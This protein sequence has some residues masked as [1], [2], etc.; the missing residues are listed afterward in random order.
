MSAQEQRAIRSS[1]RR[2]LILFAPVVA[3][4]L[5][6]SA[7][8]VIGQRT[9][10]MRDLFQFHVPIKWSQAELMR[11]GELP[12]I[13]PQRAGGQ[14]LIGNL[15]G[16][17]LY[18]D[19]LLYLVAP[20]LWAVNA[21]F[22]LHLLLAP[23]SLY[24]L[25]RRCGL[26]RE[27][28]WA[29]GTCF[30]VSGFVLSQFNL[31]NM[32]AG[33]TWAPAFVGCCL[34]AVDRSARRWAPFGVAL[35]WALLLLGGEPVLAAQALLMAALALAAR[36]LLGTGSEADGSAISARATLPAAVGLAAGTLL[37]L[38]QLV[39]LVRILGN[40]YRGFWGFSAESSLLASMNPVLMVEGLVPFF[41]G[42]PDHSFWGV[43]LF[44]AE[45]GPLFWSLFPGALCVALMLSSVGARDWG[46]RWA[47]LLLG[48]GIFLA[49]GSHN[50]VVSALAE[51][52]GASILRYPVKFMLLAQVGA[53]LLAGFGLERARR[54][55]G[56]LAAWLVALSV[57]YGRRLGSADLDRRRQER[58]ASDR[59]DSRHRQAGFDRC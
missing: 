41:Y 29:A 36:R 4:L 45:G 2:R 44:G 16:V 39:E 28:A 46:W 33:V 42:R 30:A 38:P 21:H 55:T 37:A 3:A 1:W 9:L 47:V 24:F 5:L 6:A 23:F 54:R 22:W 18:P 15:N 48:L 26:G 19:N 43:S 12:F 35:T 40:S 11:Q 57:L 17:P 59:A 58:D 8:L 51:A 31:Y 56:L 53:S 34:A 27:A 20:P 52:P 10:F 25:A 13:D 32:I 50:P 49:L 7:P 14:P